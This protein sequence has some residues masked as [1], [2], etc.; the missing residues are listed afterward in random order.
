MTDAASCFLPATTA[1]TQVL[2]LG[3]LP[4]RQSLA[5]QQ[6][7]GHPQNQFWRLVGDAIGCDLHTRDYLDKLRI[8]NSHGIGLWDVVATAQRPGS[9]DHKMRDIEPNALADFVASLP[10]L[11][12]IAFNGSTASRIGRQ[13]MGNSAQPTSLIDLPSS[14]PAYALPYAQKAQVWHQLALYV[15]SAG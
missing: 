8:I 2:I 12:A 15:S 1:E 4:G 10:Q 6:Y 9:L 13:Q 11:Q 5:R 3:S 14:S 7:Y